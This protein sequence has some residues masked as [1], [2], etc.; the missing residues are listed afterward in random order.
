MACLP[1][2]DTYRLCQVAWEWSTVGSSSLSS[3]SSTRCCLG[4]SLGNNSSSGGCRTFRPYGVWLA[5]MVPNH[6]WPD[7]VAWRQDWDMTWGDRKQQLVFIGQQL[8]ATA[9]ELLLQ[10][11][12]ITHEEE[13]GG[14][15]LWEGWP[16]PWMKFMDEEQVGS[17]S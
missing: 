14:E 16:N 4:S 11:C 17:S 12:L 5:H 10:Q 13:A 1:E 9:I 6:L 7:M 8:D 3:S 15:V 2:P